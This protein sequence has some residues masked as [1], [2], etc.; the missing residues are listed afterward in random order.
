MLSM[1]GGLGYAVNRRNLCLA[2]KGSEPKALQCGSWLSYSANVL[3]HELWFRDLG[4]CRRIP[5][6]WSH[7]SPRCTKIDN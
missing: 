3:C 6:V 7:Q 5:K 2:G 4:F 1:M